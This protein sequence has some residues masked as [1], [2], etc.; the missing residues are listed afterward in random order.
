MKK[1]EPG[2]NFLPKG[3]MST[4]VTK[5]GAVVNKPMRATVRGG[6][7]TGTRPSGASSVNAYRKALESEAYKRATPAQKRK[8]R[9][10]SEAD[11][12]QF[13]DVV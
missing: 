7:V 9:K 10:D 5:G 12:A 1:R 8:F 11:L 13:K 6:A 3:K 4:P 2:P